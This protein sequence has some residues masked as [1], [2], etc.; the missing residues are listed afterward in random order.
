L[1][2]NTLLLAI[3]GPPCQPKWSKNM[4]ATRTIFHKSD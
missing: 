4:I 1:Y 2:R 3:I